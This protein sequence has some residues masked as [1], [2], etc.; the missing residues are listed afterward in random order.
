MASVAKELGYSGTIESIYTVNHQDIINWTNY[1]H[2]RMNE[3]EIFKKFTENLPKDIDTASIV[4]TGWHVFSTFMTQFL[5]QAAAMVSNNLARHYVI[6]TAFEELGMRDSAQIHPDLFWEAAKSIG[7]TVHESVK[8]ENSMITASLSNLK[9]SL[10]SYTSDM[11]IFGVLLGLEIPAIENIETVFSS[12]AYNENAKMALEKDIFFILHREI[13]VEHVR[14]TVS[15]FLRFQKSKKDVDDFI[16]GF[17][18]GI[19]FWN[20]YWAAMKFYVIN[21]SQSKAQLGKE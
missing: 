19:K 7:I 10:L 9:S 15:N 17:T 4:A 11:Q 21:L 16:F 6:Q 1:F 8:K 20:D 12:M 3:K 18:D 13:E 5:C 2:E 14:L